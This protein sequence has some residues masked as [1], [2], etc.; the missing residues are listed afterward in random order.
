[1]PVKKDNIK[2][3]CDANLLEDNR[4]TLN[5]SLVI[6]LT[7]CHEMLMMSI[8]RIWYWINL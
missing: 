7:V 8:W 1:M 5:I 3:I 2:G 4:F 6:I